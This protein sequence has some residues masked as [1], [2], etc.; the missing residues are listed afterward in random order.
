MLRSS[1]CRGIAI[2]GLSIATAL[3]AQ[4]GSTKKD[5]APDGPVF[6]LEVRRVP[7]DI[8]VTDQQ[9]KPVTGL[10]K[11]DFVIREDGKE[12]QPLTFEWVDGT[13][14]AYVPAKMPPLPANTYL[15][16]PREPE[17]GPLYV[18]YY[19]MVNTTL[20]QQMLFRQQMLKFL[21]HAPA[22]ARMALFVNMAGLHLVQGFTTDRELLRTAITNNN[23]PGPHLPKVFLYGN[24]YGTGDAMGALSNLTWLADYLTGI[25][26]R[27]NLIW[28]SG[29]FPIPVA[30]AMIGRSGSTV[31][32]ITGGASIPTTSAAPQSFSVGSMGGPEV[33]DLTEL[34][35]KAMMRAYSAMMRAQIALY[36]VDIRGGDPETE[37]G[38]MIAD[39]ENEDM[40]AAVTGGRAFH[41]NNR[42]SELIEKAVDDGNT[43]YSLSYAPSNTKYDDSERHI[44]VTLVK[45][46]N[47]NLVYRRM[48]YATSDDSVQQQDRKRGELQ[49]RFM[50]AKAQDTLYANIEHGAPMLHDLVFS[51]HLSTA[52]Q[53]AMATPQQM[54]ALQ[55]S[56]AYFKTRKPNAP[57]KP[58]P[59]VKL[60]RYVIDY[61]VI[62]QQLKG[63]QG[64][65]GNPSVLEFAAAAYDDDGRLLNSILNQ[66]VP[67]GK[68]PEKGKPGVFHA[69]QQL[70]VPA[71]AA[72][73]RLAVRDPQTDRTGTLEVRLPLKPE[74]A[75][76]VRGESQPSASN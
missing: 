14:P 73:I 15:N 2:L 37:P 46:G 47:Y 48:Y 24:T 63:A 18:L 58:L 54:A 43:Y 55:D 3:A 31:S 44:D 41:G 70:E 53:P 62:D 49:A 11:S 5:A 8:I 66:G 56:P 39:Y 27:K 19:D 51:A 59:P 30:P 60:Q 10:K 35:R 28:M 13:T 65:N 12:Q 25:Q 67:S 61:G 7:L 52:G 20:E 32:T 72:Y 57:V 1:V 42:A 40:I 9:G 29:I 38:D 23:G 17:Q 21:D 45:K 22:G 33:L 16:L 4:S 71:H 75:L 50:E 34:M 6:R 76:A 69:Q 26:G 36:P 68:Q 74:N 64:R